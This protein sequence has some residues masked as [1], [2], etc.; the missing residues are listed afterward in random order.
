MTEEKKETQFSSKEFNSARYYSYRPRY[1]GHFYERLYEYHQGA[2]RL[3]VDV[4]CGPGEASIPLLDKF[5]EVIGVD[6]SGPMTEVAKKAFAPF[7]GRIKVV[8]SAAEDLTFLADQSVDLL[9]IA[10]AIHWFDHDVFFNEVHRVLRPGGTLAYWAYAD[11]KYTESEEVSRMIYDFTYGDNELGPYW[12]VPGHEYLRQMLRNINPPSALFTDIDR[13]YNNVQ[14]RA[15]ISVYTADY[16]DLAPDTVYEEGPW[17]SLKYTVG[18]NELFIRTFSSVSKWQED[19]PDQQPR[20]QGGTGDIVDRFMDRMKAATGWNDD[21][22][23]EVSFGIVYV[24][25]RR[26]A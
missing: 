13:V 9:L 2:T 14:N 24:R 3:A 21:T 8:R 1:P 18:T 20:S 10:E 6:P 7:G 26:A 5:D 22:V 4:G 25:A 12:Q 15:N 23:I 11:C 17:M 19:H 16:A